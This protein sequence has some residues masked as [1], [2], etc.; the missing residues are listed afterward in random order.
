MFS[1]YV[2]MVGDRKPPT[3]CPW[4]ALQQFGQWAMVKFLESED[5][6]GNWK[7]AW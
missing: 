2:A 7:M 4:E 5:P 6:S 3:A 1:S